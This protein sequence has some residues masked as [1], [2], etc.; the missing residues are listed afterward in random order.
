MRKP[1]QSWIVDS[2]LYRSQ[3]SRT[4]FQIPVVRRM[5]DPKARI[6]ESRLPYIRRFPTF[7]LLMA[8]FR[9]DFVTLVTYTKPLS[10]QVYK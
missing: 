10:L 8:L 2:T 5:R 9:V 1:R 3:I 7:P 6:L 4:G